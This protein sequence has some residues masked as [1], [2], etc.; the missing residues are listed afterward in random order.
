MMVSISLPD[1]ELVV[2]CQAVC[3]QGDAA[4]RHGAQ[5]LRM[6]GSRSSIY[7]DWRSDKN[8]PPQV[9]VLP[10]TAENTSCSVAMVLCTSR[11]LRHQVEP[12]QQGF[13]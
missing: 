3:A 7:T 12:G 9:G 13:Q 2:G 4:R 8:L 1:A 6:S 11:G 5:Q 10:E